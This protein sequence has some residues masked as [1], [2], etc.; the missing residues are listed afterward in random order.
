M[1]IDRSLNYYTIL[2]L[3][4]FCERAG[5]N[6]GIPYTEAFMLLHQEEKKSEG[7]RLMVQQSK[8]KTKGKPALQEG[9]GESESEDMLFQNLN[10]PSSQPDSPTGQAGCTSSCSDHPH[11]TNIFTASCFP[12][13]WGSI[14]SFY[15]NPR[16]TGAWFGFT[17]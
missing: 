7:S 10:A 17:I 3:E 1:A 15:V 6:D 4:L 13:L 2:Q 12:Y 11:A 14:R 5:K 8:R 16:G 9:E